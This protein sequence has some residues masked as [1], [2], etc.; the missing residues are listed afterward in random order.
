MG[1][2][3]QGILWIVNKTSCPLEQSTVVPEEAAAIGYLNK[4][5]WHLLS[6][7]LL[8]NLHF[9]NLFTDKVKNS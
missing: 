2:H 8:P 1:L 9:W 6:P 5:S 4:N 3:Q 7:K